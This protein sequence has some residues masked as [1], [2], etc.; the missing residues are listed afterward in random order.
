[1]AV[2]SALLEARALLQQIAQAACAMEVC[3]AM[4]HLC[5]YLLDFLTC[6]PKV[7]VKPRL[8][9]MEHATVLNRFVPCA[10]E[11]FGVT[12]VIAGFELRRGLSNEVPYW[13]V[14]RQPH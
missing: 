3:W 13:F 10:L 12:C 8:A 14:V 4:I 6:W 2:L 7:C 5:F 9:R 1:M 11:F